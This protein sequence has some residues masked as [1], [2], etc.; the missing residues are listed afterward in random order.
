MKILLKSFN[1]NSVRFVRFFNELNFNFVYNWNLLFL[2]RDGDK[3]ERFERDGEFRRSIGELFTIFLFPIRPAERWQDV[4]GLHDKY[5]S[6]EIVID[7]VSLT[8]MTHKG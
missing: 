5:T 6:K 7:N 4:G 3:N 8:A 2:W 1:R